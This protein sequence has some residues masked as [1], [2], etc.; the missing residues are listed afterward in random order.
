MVSRSD[1]HKTIDIKSTM[2]N[3]QLCNDFYIKLLIM[4]TGSIKDWSCTKDYHLSKSIGPT[5]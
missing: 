3:S 4:Y 2:Q 1:K 5:S